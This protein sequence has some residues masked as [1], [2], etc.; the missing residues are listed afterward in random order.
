MTRRIAGYR[1]QNQFIETSLIVHC[2]GYTDAG[3]YSKERFRGFIPSFNAKK[4]R[5]CDISTPFRRNLPVE[6]TPI[7]Y[8]I[9]IPA[10]CRNQ[11]TRQPVYKSEL[12][13]LRS[14]EE[15]VLYSN[16]SY[17][18]A[19]TRWTTIFYLAWTFPSSNS[20]VTAELIC[21]IQYPCTSGCPLI[22]PCYAIC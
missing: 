19:T 16:P 10:Q 12:N 13:L 14:K 4:C 17:F 2:L 9:Q 1:Y 22:R 21:Y 15:A 3:Q 18:S 8:P 20:R 7:F 11:T 6:P 5:K